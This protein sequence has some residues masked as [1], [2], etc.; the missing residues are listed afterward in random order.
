MNIDVSY[1]VCESLANT[2]KAYKYIDKIYNENKEKYFEYMNEFKKQSIEYE[3]SIIQE[4][5]FKKMHSIMTEHNIEK[6][7]YIIKMTYKKSAQ[8]VKD[9]DII[10]LLDFIKNFKNKNISD[11]ELNG[12][13]LSVIIL[14][15]YENKK[16]NENDPVYLDFMNVLFL[17][18]K[19]L[20]EE[21]FLSYSKFDKNQKKQLRNIQLSF[22]NKYNIDYTWLPVASTNENMI[23]DKSK[24]TEAELRLH[25]LSYIFDME[26]ISINS[27]VG[28][29]FF[30][31]KDIQE[32]IQCYLSLQNF[33]NKSTD[34]IDYE[35]LYSFVSTGI[36]LRYMIR[37]YKEAKKYFFKN[38]TD[39]DM[40]ETLRKT[41]EELNLNK[42]ENFV[43]KG[44]NAKLKNNHRKEIND[45]KEQIRILEN[46]NKK[47]QEEINSY[48]VIKDELHELRNLMFNLNNEN[49][50]EN[51]KKEIDLEY[52]NSIDAIC[53]GGTDNWVKEMKELLPNWIFVSANSNNFDITLLSKKD[54]I[55]INTVSN[56]HKMY[57]R[58]IDNKDKNSK[59]RYINSINK[60]R[61][62]HEINKNINR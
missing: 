12:F 3:G 37:A 42:Q 27:I 24:M 14:S 51:N 41:E 18:T 53:F 1:F 52:I 21:H 33:L 23:M 32:L 48:P 22:I 54:Y 50:I 61:V 55:F 4:Y 25:F 17:R 16:I 15:K 39:D 60:D 34:N 57:Y 47:L 28:N 8:F 13:I 7:M 49:I 29:N 6:E 44:E 58:V 40:I 38:V 45:L 31:D 19:M 56:S 62:L 26:H 36:Y 43:L 59:L 5:Y 30:K 9:H 20:T 11:D 35:D 10:S 2:P 46:N